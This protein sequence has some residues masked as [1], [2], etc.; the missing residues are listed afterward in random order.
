M[1]NLHIE[2]ISKQQT[3]KPIVTNQMNDDGSENFD[4]KSVNDVQGNDF[5]TDQ[6]HRI[7]FVD[8]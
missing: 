4:S 2:D 8:L 7:R 6:A 1:D 5:R 3:I